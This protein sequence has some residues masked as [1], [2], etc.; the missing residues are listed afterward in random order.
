MDRR[1]NRKN[2]GNLRFWSLFY[3]FF[4]LPSEF[5]HLCSGFVKGIWAD[6]VVYNPYNKLNTSRGAKVAF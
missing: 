5:N 1:M 6:R 3:F 2:P 4:L